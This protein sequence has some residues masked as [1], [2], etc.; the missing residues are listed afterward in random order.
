MLHKELAD[1]VDA[2][3]SDDLSQIVLGLSTLDALL[4]DLVPSVRR[5]HQSGTCDERLSAFV[6]T[7]HNFQYNLASAILS[8]YQTFSEDTEKIRVDTLILM[9]RLLLGIL[10]IHPDSRKN[11]GHRR[12]MQLMISFL[13]PSH[14]TFLI[15]LCVSFI[16]LLVHI[17]LQNVKNMRVFEQCG[18]CQQ[19]IRHLDPQKGGTAGGGNGSAQQHLY[20]KVIEFLIFYL[21]DESE[22]VPGD[23]KTIEEKA[24]LFR[25][26]FPGIDDLIANLNDLASL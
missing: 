20:F 10:L 23:T 17:L 11:F 6:A 2:L 15:D 26:D 1:I 3:N 21:T 14:P 13:D 19:V 12:A 18:G 22:L 9:N 25:P 24:S 4:H 16:S 5:F 7:Q 8:A